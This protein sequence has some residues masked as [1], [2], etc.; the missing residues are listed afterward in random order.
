MD[1]ISINHQLYM[2]MLKLYS[3][4]A[5]KKIF[6]NL[7]KCE[8]VMNLACKTASEF[9]KMHGIIEVDKI[10][11]F[12]VIQIIIRV[13]SNKNKNYHKCLTD[14]S[15][16]LLCESDI[17]IDDEEVNE[18]FKCLYNDPVLIKCIH[19]I[20]AEKLLKLLEIFDDNIVFLTRS[21]CK[22]IKM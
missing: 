11:D 1:S 5:Y 14:N 20:A 13:T 22:V 3:S 12:V 18:I 6:K 21:F 2:D 19:A 8:Y 4:S 10:I 15:D 9:D 17:V 7:H 16:F